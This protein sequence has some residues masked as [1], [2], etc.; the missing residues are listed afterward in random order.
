[1]NATVLTMDVELS[2][3]ANA[4]VWPNL[5]FLNCAIFLSVVAG[6]L[7]YRA[8]RH[9]NALVKAPYIG[10]SWSWLARAQF[11]TNAT[12]IVSRGYREVGA[13]LNRQI[14]FTLTCLYSSSTRLSR[15]LAMT[16]LLFQRHMSKNY[17]NSRIHTWMQYRR[18]RM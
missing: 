13:E 8:P 17:D 5:P 3:I 2:R 1:M 4:T 6:L 14:R 12:Q 11:L 9:G 16:C 15:F 10:P 7:L 18:I